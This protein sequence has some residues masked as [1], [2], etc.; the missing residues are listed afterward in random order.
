MD[1]QTFGS[2]MCELG[3][4]RERHKAPSGKA[5]AHADDDDGADA[6]RAAMNVTAA[7]ADDDDADDANDALHDGSDGS[8]DD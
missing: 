4:F 1:S 7:H 3:L 5:A 6:E 8:D 2:V